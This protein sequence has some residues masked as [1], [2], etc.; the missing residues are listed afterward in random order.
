MTIAVVLLLTETQPVAEANSAQR[1]W[2]GTD[3]AGTVIKDGESPIIVEKEVLTFDIPEFPKQYY[4]DEEEYLAYDAKVTAEYTFYN[5]SE[6]QVTASLFFPFGNEPEY[7]NGAD[8]I[9]KY[10]ILVQ[11]KPIEKK[12]RYSFASV[13]QS[14]DLEQSLAKLQDGHMEDDFYAPDMTVT[15]YRY[16][17]S[18]VDSATYKAANAAFDIGDETERKIYFVEQ[19][20]FHMQDDG[21]KRISAWTKN[22]DEYTVY[23]IGKP[24]QESLPWKFYKNGGAE[25]TE[26]IDGTMTLKE[27]RT[28]TLYEFAMANYD[29]SGEIGEVDWYNAVIAEMK[30]T[31][32][33]E[34][35]GILCLDCYARNY[36]GALLRWYEY[37][38][39]IEPEER[40]VNTVTAPLYPNIDATYDPEVYYYTYLLSPAKTWKAFWEL[41]VVIRTPYYVTVSSID[42]LTAVSDGYRMF[43]DGLPEG[44]FRFAMSTSAEPKKAGAY[45]GYGFGNRVV[46]GVIFAVGIGLSAAGLCVNLRKKKRKEID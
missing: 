35:S 20:G 17:V 28:M 1:K 7:A 42:G 6:Y 43:L 27:S 40:I 4:P 14:F 34:N 23:V 15:E 3:V 26:E 11:G 31:E 22:A 2:E 16:T 44:E 29:A 5:P 38:I 9:E 45:A 41:E 37:E 39:T 25:D 24:L 36:E 13:T 8:D 19:S 30:E 10:D 32:I 18:G 46:R 21:I 33:N 12:I